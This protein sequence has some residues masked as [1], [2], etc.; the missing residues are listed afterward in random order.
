LGLG[1]LDPDTPTQYRARVSTRDRRSRARRAALLGGALL[2]GMALAP[3]LA[4]PD[5]PA[6]CTKVLALV[7]RAGEPVGP[8]EREA[9]EQHYQRVRESRGVLGWTWISWC[10]RFANSIPEAGEC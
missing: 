8:S 7:E 10:T 9:C 6:T 1:T 5:V 3:L 2:V 4:A